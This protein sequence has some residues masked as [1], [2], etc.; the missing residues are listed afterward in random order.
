GVVDAGEVVGAVLG[1]ALR[2]DLR[3]PLRV[4]LVGTVEVEAAARGAGVSGHGGDGLARQA[5]AT[6]VDAQ[7]AVAGRVAQGAPTVVGHGLDVELDGV[8]DGL[9]QAV[10]ARAKR[11][12]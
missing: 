7:L 5:R 6:E 12:S 10:V 4:A 11:G 2:P 8:E 3:G 9:A 1:L